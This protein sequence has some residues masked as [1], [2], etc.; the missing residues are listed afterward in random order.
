[1]LPSRLNGSSPPLPAVPEPLPDPPLPDE[2]VD[3]LLRYESSHARYTKPEK[4][5]QSASGMLVPQLD[6]FTRTSMSVQSKATTDDALGL[7]KST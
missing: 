7:D 3:A 4:T 1:M 6:L 5:T 2:L